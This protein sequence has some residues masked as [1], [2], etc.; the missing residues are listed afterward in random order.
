MHMFGEAEARQFAL[1]VACQTFGCEAP[2]RGEFV[3]YGLELFP[4]GGFLTF[5]P[6]DVEPAGV[7]ERQVLVDLIP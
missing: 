5:E 1:K 7:E 3:E 2:R 6:F 4:Q